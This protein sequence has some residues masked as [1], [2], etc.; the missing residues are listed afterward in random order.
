MTTLI[1]ISFPPIESI[2]S[3]QLKSFFHTFSFISANTRFFDL[4]ITDGRLR[5]FPCLES[6]IGPRISKTSLLVSRSVLWLK[7]T[8]DLSVLIFFPEAT[9]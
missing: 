5:Y 4:P 3:F 8:E 6:Y 1:S 7:V 2:F 9:S